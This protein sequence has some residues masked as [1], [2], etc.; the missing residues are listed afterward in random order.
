LP[1]GAAV[2]SRLNR[3]GL[4]P[5][6]VY[7]RWL[8]QGLLVL[9]LLASVR[10]SA[11]ALDSPY[12]LHL[13]ADVTTLSLSAVTW[14][15]PTLFRSAFV[16]A[17]RCPCAATAVN[18]LDREVAGVYHPS[19]SLAGDI[20]LASV[21]TLTLLLDALDVAQSDEPVRSWLTDVVVMA[22]ALLLN[23]A[24]NEIAKVGAGR[25]RP[26]VY[27]RA[28]G[29]PQLTDPE[30]YVSFYSAH[31]SSAFALSFAY[32]Q[33]FALR[34]PRSPWRYVVYGAAIGVGTAIGLSRI[35]AGKHF[36]TDVMTG[37]ATG[38]GFGLLVPWLHARARPQLAFQLAPY[39]LGFSL[40]VSHL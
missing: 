21:Y 22:E 11:H 24:V 12:R 1:L 29:D 2:N 37:A 32:A 4:K 10:A 27:N 23:G 9:G 25:P 7:K 35:A 14:W 3:E 33:T 6:P 18:A 13:A 26:L 39:G 19:L 20:A 17:D 36:P 28:T 31:T 40:A 5:R 15:G 34:H 16:R 8:V 30:N 38:T